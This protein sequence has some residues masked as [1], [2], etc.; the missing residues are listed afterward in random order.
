MSMIAII[1]IAILLVL[2]LETSSG[3]YYEHEVVSSSISTTEQQHEQNEPPPYSLGW[4]FDDPATQA[5]T[6]ETELNM[7][8]SI[9]YETYYNISIQ[10]SNMT[11]ILTEKLANPIAAVVESKPV[12]EGLLSASRLRRSRQ[13]KVQEQVKEEEV[14]LSCTPICSNQPNLW[15]IYDGC[16]KKCNNDHA[17]MNDNVHELTYEQRIMLQNYRER[18][19]N[20]NKKQGHIGEVTKILYGQGAVTASTFYTTVRELIPKFDECRNILL[21]MKYQRIPLILNPSQ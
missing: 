16:Q 12:S 19:N 14:S 18:H 17:D 2:L 10:D 11:T 9:M 5:N 20:A 1:Y 13:L 21:T 4:Y 7:I 8:R 6:C 3:A 15:L